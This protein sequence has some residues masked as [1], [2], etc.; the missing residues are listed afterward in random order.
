MRIS[1]ELNFVNHILP[2]GGASGIAYMNWRMNQ[3][4]VTIARATMAQ[5][6]RYVA[7]F[8][9]AI[10]M[11]LFGLLAVTIDGSVNRWIIL[12]SA[13]V[14]IAMMAGGM[15]EII[16]ENGGSNYII[17]KITAHVSNKQGAK[18]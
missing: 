8:M 12:M 9:A 11:L 7:G 18:R 1:L 13:A 3:L 15:L 6:V 16:R 17:D 5:A 4:G 2:S 10:V 14:I